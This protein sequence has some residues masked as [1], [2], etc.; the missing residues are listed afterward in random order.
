MG[1]GQTGL[2]RGLLTPG[3][4]TFFCLS[5]QNTDSIITLKNRGIQVVQSETLQT[6][7]LGSESM[8]NFIDFYQEKGLVVKVFTSLEDTK[9]WMASVD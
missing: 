6:S 2:R 9:A 8:T 1:D 5:R 4:L 7:I 3:Y